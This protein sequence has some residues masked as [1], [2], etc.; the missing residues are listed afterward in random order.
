MKSKY[1]EDIFNELKDKIEYDSDVDALYVVINKMLDID[2]NMAVDW[3]KY[4]LYTYDFNRLRKEID[5]KGIIYDMPLELL[6]RGLWEEFWKVRSS[7]DLD[8]IS[9]LDDKVFNVY[10]DSV[11]KETLEFMIMENEVEKEKEF[12][13]YILKKES[14]SR[15]IFDLTDFVKMI[16]IM[17]LK[18]D[19]IDIAWLISLTEYPKDNKDK[20]KLKTLLI[21]YI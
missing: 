19:R 14:I 6:K 18:Y 16:I 13:N 4:L 17:H 15:E 1:F 10:K 21:D 5:F 2:V 9:V 3:W 12:I 20:A 8:K 11:I 7:L